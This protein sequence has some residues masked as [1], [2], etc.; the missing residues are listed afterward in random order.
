MPHHYRH[1]PV[2][3]LH[4]IGESF[5]GTVALF[6]GT[7]RHERLL[8][9]TTISSLH[10][11]ARMRILDDW[12][13]L[14][15]DT[16]SMRAWS[17]RTMIYRFF[18]GAITSEALKWFR[19]LQDRTDPILVREVARLAKN[20]DLTPLLRE[21]ALPTLLIASVPSFFCLLHLRFL[22]SEATRAW[23]T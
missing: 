8:S 20:T 21:L 13:E 6:T 18:Q 15:E 14:A 12:Q 4:L 9:V 10:R 1:C 11:G 17:E 5:G 23:C 16:E 19:T 2:G 22:A 7:T 3:R